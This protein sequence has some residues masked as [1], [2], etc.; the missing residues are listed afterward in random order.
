MTIIAIVILFIEIIILMVERTERLKARA[1][2]VI[3]MHTAHSSIS[4]VY[5]NTKIARVLQ[6]RIIV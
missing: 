1:P 6:N 4:I 5:L 2:P 3:I